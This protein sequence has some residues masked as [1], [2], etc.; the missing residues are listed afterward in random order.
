VASANVTRRRW[1]AG[2]G[3]ALG[4]VALAAC[5][6]S[7][8]STPAGPSP[9]TPAAGGGAATAATQA[10]PGSGIVTGPFQG[11]AKDLTGAGA[12]FPA[13]LYTKW[14]DTYYNLTQVKVN[15]QAIGSGGGIKAI[16]DQTVDFGA[17]DAPMTDDQLSQAKG[18]PLFHVPMTL[19]GT[20]ATYN[21]P[22][23]PANT[24]LRFS[25]ETLAAIFLGD[26]TK[27]SDALI[28]ADNPSATLPDKE[29]VT[30]HRSDA[31][32]TTYNFTDYLS[33]VSPKWKD[34]IGASTSVNWPGGIGGKGSEGV[35]GEVKQNPYSLGY[36]EFIYAKQNG[37]GY[38]QIKNKAGNWVT[39]NPETV[40]AAAAGAAA[41]MPA[42]LRVSIVN[43]EG[44]QAY[45]ISTFT[46]ILAYQNMTDEAKAIALTR[47]LWWCT[48]DG[49]KFSADLGYAPLPLEV[50]K[51]DEEKIKA[52]Q[53]NGKPAFP[54][55]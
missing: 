4:G 26:V 2:L 36:V 54:N 12:T 44:A 7:Q 55:K 45:P 41:T 24:Q 17:S 53:A 49:Q 15:Y 32:G 5:G 37:L 46:W 38:A 52:I 16:S 31:S 47:L 13:V 35:S 19:G 21:I 6:A 27:W 30:V 18:G 34:Q 9:A 51:L 28:K 40:T 11:E 43:A 1:L 29:I 50:I 42:D 48:H 10:I 3:T 14:F 25:G 39:P 22:E 8:T 23:V 33:A 20:V